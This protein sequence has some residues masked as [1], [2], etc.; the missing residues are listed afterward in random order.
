MKLF[1]KFSYLFRKNPLIR[2]AVFAGL[3]I[4]CMSISLGI[5]LGIKIPPQLS[6]V[7]PQIANPGD[8][9]YIYGRHFGNTISDSY[10]EIAGNRITSSHYITW[11][12][13]TIQMQLPANISDGLLY[14]VTKN[15][16]SKAINFTNR[17]NVPTLVKTDSVSTLPSIS[18]VDGRSGSIGN[19]IRINGKN[20]GSLR[21]NSKVYFTIQGENGGTEFITCPETENYYDFWN[22]QEIRVRVPDGVISGA[23]FVKTSEG[24]SNYYNLTITNMPGKKTFSSKKTYLLGLKADISATDFRGSS[25]VIMRFPIPPKT[26]TQRDIEIPYSK[27]EPEIENYMNTIVHETT[28]TS[29]QKNLVSIE[30]TFLVPVYEIQTSINP[31]KVKD[32]SENT[33]KFLA[34][35]LKENEIIPCSNESAIA[36]QKKISPRIT[37]PYSRAEAIYNYIIKNFKIENENKTGEMDI[38]QVIESKKADAYDATM[39]YCTLLRIAGIPSVPLAGFYI[40]ADKETHVHWWCEFY[41]EN[42]G[43]IPV[44]IALGSGMEYPGLE[45]IQ[46]QKEYYFGSLDSNHVAF[47]RGWNKIISTNINN[48]TV[49]IPRTFALQSIWEETSSQVQSYSSYWSKAHVIGVY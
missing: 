29:R 36:L 6:I 17:V 38:S 14:V 18:T 44:D 15:G 39:L 48:K 47:S 30:H 4:I 5:T 10:V 1:S 20:F 42:F 7:T 43:W 16:K 3:I 8:T 41:I 34:Q 13:N 40:D 45:T 2:F 32:C 12:D 19:I 23:I 25:D 37:N 28:I 27:P 9:I 24:E 46:N 35:Y 33:K 21:K 11:T 49:Y 22:N 26:M 31:E